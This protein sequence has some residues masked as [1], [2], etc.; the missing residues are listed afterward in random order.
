MARF[1]K[2][3]MAS[4]LLFI[5]FA[6]CNDFARTQ[7]LDSVNGQ[8]IDGLLKEVDKNGDR[9][10]A[11]QDLV[12]IQSERTAVL[13]TIAATQS[14]WFRAIGAAIIGLLFKELTQVIRKPG[15]FTGRE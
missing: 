7:T 2:Y 8:R 14:W 10:D 13:E 3:L 4:C 1:R 12:R 9:L 6:A 15:R 5:V 11:L